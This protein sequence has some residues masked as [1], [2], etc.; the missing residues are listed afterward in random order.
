MINIT[1]E[2]RGIAGGVAQSLSEER[3]RTQV[4]IARLESRNMVLEAR[5]M[6]LDTRLL[7]L[8][9]LLRERT[10]AAASQSAP[11]FN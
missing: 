5:L 3:E 4:H 10:L 8:E 2:I 1:P 7:V 11:S 6:Q 9:G